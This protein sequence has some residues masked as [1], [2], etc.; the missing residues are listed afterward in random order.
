MVE[1]VKLKTES[2]P[3]RCEICH[4][5]DY[6]DPETNDCSRCESISISAKKKQ[7]IYHAKHAK[8]DSAGEKALDHGIVR[9]VTAIFLPIALLLKLTHGLELLIILASVISFVEGIISLIDWKYL[10]DGEALPFQN[11][12]SLISNIIMFLAI[13]VCIAQQLLNGKTSIFLSSIAGMLLMFSCLTYYR[14][15]KKQTGYQGEIKI[16]QK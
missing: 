15:Y 5:S 2:Q 1:K 14:S 4:Q 7:A 11:Y 6:F 13:S 16:K 9:I 12:R 3:K 8:G 10:R